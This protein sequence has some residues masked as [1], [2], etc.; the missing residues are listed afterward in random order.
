LIANIYVTLG[1]ST[2]GP[3]GLK[4]AVSEMCNNL[5]H[6]EDDGDL[7]SP[8]FTQRKRICRIVLSDDSEDEPPVGKIT[9]YEAKPVVSNEE[10]LLADPKPVVGNMPSAGKKALTRSRQP[11]AADYD[12]TTCRILNTAIH[13]YHV[14][15]LTDNPF[16]DVQLELEFA[17]EAW[18]LSCEYY[19]STNLRLDAGLISVVSDVHGLYTTCST[20]FRLQQEAQACV[21]NSKQKH[22]QLLLLPMGSRWVMGPPPER[23]IGIWLLS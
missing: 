22:K 7:N 4:P 12:M 15:L 6:S 19:Q 9:A 17:R 10:S 8:P 23:K 2:E 20:L 13:I 16:P 11:K 5:D 14:L 21:E 18:D 1:R 3:K